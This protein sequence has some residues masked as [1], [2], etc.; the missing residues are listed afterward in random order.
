M[1]GKLIERIKNEAQESKV[2]RFVE[3]QSNNT[4]ARI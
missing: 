1:I 4:K 3:K 2:C